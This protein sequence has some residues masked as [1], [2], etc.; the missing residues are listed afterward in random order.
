M[1]GD[2]GF[3]NI[4]YEF[5]TDLIKVIDPR[6][7][8][9]SGDISIYDDYL[10]HVEKLSHS[11]LDMYDWIIEGNYTVELSG[12]I[13]ILIP[14]ILAIIVNARNVFHLLIKV[15]FL[16]PSNSTQGGSRF[17][18]LCYL[19]IVMIKYEKNPYLKIHFVFIS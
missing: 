11:I 10:Y 1:Y 9:P 7:I 16:A 12:K 5:R 15:M 4:L 6:G 13:L 3:S 18:Y 17:S 2:S 8:F 14:I 19:Y